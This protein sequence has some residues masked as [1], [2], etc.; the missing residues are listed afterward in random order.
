MQNNATL[1]AI[2]NEKIIIGNDD[3][4]TNANF[5]P[6]KKPTLSID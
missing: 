4:I 1:D 5:H 6:F 3:D 2:M